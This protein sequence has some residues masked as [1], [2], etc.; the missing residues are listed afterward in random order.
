MSTVDVSPLSS[1]AFHASKVF[2]AVLSLKPSY[3]KL[4][5]ATFVVHVADLPENGSLCPA[6]VVDSTNRPHTTYRRETWR[7]EREHVGKE[8]QRISATLVKMRT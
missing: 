5:K 7:E 2:R 3:V 1:K 4:P 6:L 8:I